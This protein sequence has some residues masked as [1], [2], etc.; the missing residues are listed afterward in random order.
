MKRSPMIANAC[1]ETSVTFGVCWSR[2]RG[3]VRCVAAL[4]RANNNSC[5]LH[6]FCVVIAG[7]DIGEP[8]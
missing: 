2:V 8:T 7:G 1:S 4:L 5:G 3:I 6:A